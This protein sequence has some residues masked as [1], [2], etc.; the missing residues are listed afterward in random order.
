MNHALTQA[1][2][3][4]LEE[5]ATIRAGLPINYAGLLGT[6]KDMGSYVEDG[7]DEKCRTNLDDEKVKQFKEAVKKHLSKLV[8]HI[9]VNKSADAM[10][11]DFMASR[12][13]PYTPDKSDDGE[14]ED[15]EQEVQLD[16]KVK[17]KF[18][19]HVRVVYVNAEDNDEEDDEDDDW[20]EDEDGEEDDERPPSA[21]KSPKKS[22]AKRKS[23]GGEDEDDEEADVGTVESCIRV[24]HSLNNNRALHMGPGAGSW[25]L[26]LGEVR[27]DV[28]FAKAVV[29]LVNSKDFVCVKDVKMEDDQ[30]KLF[31][32]NALL[33]HRLIHIQDKN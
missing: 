30:D 5:D 21:K 14:E 19:D 16:D 10:C 32:V 23:V 1:I 17:I 29:E 8:D 4:A 22:P 18:P 6:G 15:D 25:V 9:D 12:L 2:E 26:A 20:G 11:A 27:L 13:P 24:V 7:S 33:E 28:S 31:L 3:T